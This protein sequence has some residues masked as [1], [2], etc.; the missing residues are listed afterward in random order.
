MKLEFTRVDEEPVSA[1]GSGRKAIHY[2]VKV[3]VPSVTGASAIASLLGKMPPYS[4]VWILGGEAPAFV[5]SES[6]LFRRLHHR[7][8]PRRG[9]VPG[10]SPH[11]V[12][13]ASAPPS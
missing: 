5:K 7:H 3:H 6:P 9:I 2:V 4:H 10:V 8:V 12:Q 13:P 1:A 11:R